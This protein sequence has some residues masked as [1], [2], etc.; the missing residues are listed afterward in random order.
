MRRLLALTLFL[1]AAAP[2]QA[3]VSFAPTVGYDERGQAPTLGLALEAGAPLYGVPLQPSVRALVE[4][5]FGQEDTFSRDPIDVIHAN[6]DLI[7][8]FGGGYSALSP[9]A[10]GGLALTSISGRRL[11]PDVEVAAS[12][13]GGLEA[14]RFFAEGEYAFGDFG[15]IR[16]R[17]G[18][19][20]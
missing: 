8:R 20:F 14:S 12:L 5:V 6:L 18:Y 10:K 3:Q 19:R 16:A 15:G 11:D 1:T 7:G 17:V 13:G 9:Y 4:Y 2:A